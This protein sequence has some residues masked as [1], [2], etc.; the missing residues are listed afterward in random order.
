M[1]VALCALLCSCFTAIIGS[2]F[3]LTSNDFIQGV[4]KGQ[5]CFVAMI[6]IRKS[7][8]RILLQRT[9]TSPRSFMVLRQEL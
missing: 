6:A 4:C 2:V 9:D 5:S 3:V 1:Y 7:V 8:I